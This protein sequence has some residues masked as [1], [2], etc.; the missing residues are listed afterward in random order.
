MKI[1]FMG[2]PQLAAS[3]LDA[4]LAAGCE[5]SLAV[6]QPDRPRG[7]GRGV[8]MTPVKECALRHDIPVFAPEKIRDPEA[9]ERIRQESPDLIVVAAYGQILPKALLEIP[10][11]GC[12][13][14]HASLLPRYRGAAP[15][16]RA[17]IDGEKTTG[18]TIMK[19]DEGLDTGDIL[20]QRRIDLAPDETA[21]SLYDKL[22]VLGGEALLEALPGLENG[23][24]VPIKQND[25][26][27]SYAP[28]ISKS[29]GN[30]D[31][32]LPAQELERLVRG[33]NSWP[34]AYTYYGGKTLKIWGAAVRSQEDLCGEDKAEPGRIAAVDKKT[35]YVQ[36]GKDLLGLTEVQLEG[37]KRMPVQAFLLGCRVREGEAF[38]RQR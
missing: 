28:M 30:L 17:V 15:I 1:I 12:V 3:V 23:T 22:S 7:R 26:E 18:V 14:V 37:K 36:C 10:P 11:L 13:N 6:T 34:G 27:S 38:E 9:V 19:M 8:V 2:T 32:S 25:A 5:V 29:L 16:Q 20:L 24:I 35:I 4:M 31:W 33:L 21:D